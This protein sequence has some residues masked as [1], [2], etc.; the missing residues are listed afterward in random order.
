AF[1]DLAVDTDVA[2][3]VDDH[4]KAAIG[5]L[6]DVADQRRLPRAEE[7]GDDG[8]RHLG[9]AA[10]ADSLGRDIGGTR[11]MVFLRTCSGRSRHT[12]RPSALARCSRAKLAMSST[13][14]SG[15]RWPT[16]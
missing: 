15:S 13:F 1:Q 14:T 3:L 10:H 6:Q 12:V 16:T 7:A 9:E 11:A 8:A 2:E 5:V 4:G